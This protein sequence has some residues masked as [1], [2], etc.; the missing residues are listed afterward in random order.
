M[1]EQRPGNVA[2]TRQER[3]LV[4][5]LRLSGATML[6]A[7]AAIF[8]PVD[9]MAATHRWLGLGEFPVAPIVD[10]LT[11]SISAL[12]GIHGGLLILVSGNVRRYAGVIL[13]LIVMGFVFGVLLLGIDFYAG[14]PTSWSVGEGPMIIV[15]SAVLLL[16][17][18]SV[19][20]DE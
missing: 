19:P 15:L 11:R 12:Y 8:L 1:D 17:L 14:L 20:R 16:L 9:W 7:F 2:T 5:L 6:P 18:R 4:F 3:V 10:Y 13:Y